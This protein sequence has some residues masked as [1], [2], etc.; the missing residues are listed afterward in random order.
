MKN[1]DI[2]NNLKKDLEI[3]KQSPYDKK[4]V[5][6]QR[7]ESYIETYKVIVVL[8]GMLYIV[9]DVKKYVIV[10]VEVQMK[11]GILMNMDVMQ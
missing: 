7:D 10:I 4:K 8:D 9:V 11:V 3:C 5:I 1:K 2:I 6:K